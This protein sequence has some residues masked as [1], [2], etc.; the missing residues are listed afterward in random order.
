L[1]GIPPLFI[2]HP[3]S[4]ILLFVAFGAG[5]AN[6]QEAVRLRERF[7]AGY[8]YGVR[9][10]VD[11]AGTLTPPAANGK[12]A[13]KPLQFQ[14]DSA[15]EYDERVLGVNEKGEVTKTLRL[16]RRMDFRRRVADR[17]QQTSLRPAVKRL[18]VL[19]KGSTEVPFSPDGPLTWGEIDLVRT[20]VFTPALAGLLPD[21][22]VRVGERWTATTAAIQEL[23]DMERIDEG[24]LECRLDELQAAV[25][26]RVAKVSFRGTVRGTNEDGPNRQRL[27]G[28]L[29]FDLQTNALT[30][31]Q[32][33]GVHSLLDKDGREVGHIEGRF[34]LQRVANTHNPSLADSALRG[35]KLEPSAENTLLLY[36]NPDLGVRLLHP[37]RWHVAAVR[38]SQVTLDTSDGSGLLLTLD[39]LTRVPTGAAFLTEARGWLQKQKAKVLRVVSPSRLSGSPP[40]EHFA[41]D[42]EMGGKR[43]WME[44]YA[45]RQAHGGF[46]VAARLAPRDLSALRKEVL[47]IARSVVI[48]KKLAAAR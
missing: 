27:D 42:V 7:P 28:H 2:L 47:A 31:L 17:P 25:K 44:Y 23:T 11:L 20:D 1:P 24:K 30:Y 38:G 32:L 14:G 16:V 6:A 39:P 5:A 40:L 9:A 3:S 18:V 21:R 10:R 29:H 12:P 34:V 45:A 4:F 36:D 43:F 33:K 48:T 13:P 37:R 46:T 22:A 15:I 19:R 41:L 26:R 35:V 8:Q